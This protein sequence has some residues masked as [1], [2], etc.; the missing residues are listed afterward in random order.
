MAAI[1]HLQLSNDYWC[2][3]VLSEKAAVVRKISNEHEFQYYAGAGKVRLIFPF[4]FYPPVFV[5]C[6]DFTL[7]I[8]SD[9][10]D[11]QEGQ[12]WGKKVKDTDVPRRCY[13]TNC[14]TGL[15]KCS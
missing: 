7:L 8:R 3:F 6:K 9:K 14:M 2:R 12:S 1:V 15:D 13:E 4:V 5:F 10:L 11:I